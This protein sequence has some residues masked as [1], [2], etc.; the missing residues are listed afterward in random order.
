MWLNNC[1]F[2]QTR[3]DY[4]RIDSALNKEVN[5]TDFL[6]FLFKYSYKLLADDFA[7]CFRLAYA[8]KLWIKAFLRVHADKVQIIRTIWTKYRF[9]LVSFVFAKQT[10]IDENTGK[11][12]ADS[13]WQQYSR[14]WRVHTTGK[15]AKHLAVTD[16]FTDFT[17]SS[18]NEAVHF[19]VAPAT[20]NL[21]NK[22]L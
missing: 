14:N 11:L 6:C 9:N 8:G 21:E 3:L 4:I 16:F 17:N 15:R 5:S 12:L 1:G 20:A 19:P 10:V 2:A 13:L 7:L 22:I 18:L